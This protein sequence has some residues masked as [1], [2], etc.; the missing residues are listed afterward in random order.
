[1]PSRRKVS[2]IRLKPSL[3]FNAFGTSE[4][5]PSPE[6]PFP[7]MRSASLRAG[8]R[9]KEKG[10]FLL[11]PALT[12]QHVRKERAHAVSTCWATFIHPLRGLEPRHS[13][14]TAWFEFLVH[15]T[16]PAGVVGEDTRLHTK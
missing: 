3:F 14:I 4:L 8:L 13:Y 7:Y 16:T 6:T 5:M 15:A 9:R 10:L 12:R 2:D 1:M 11:Y